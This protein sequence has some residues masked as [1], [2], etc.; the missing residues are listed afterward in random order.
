MMN[1]LGPQ[2]DDARLALAIHSAKLFGGLH[3]IEGLSL[4]GQSVFQAVQ[5]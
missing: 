3:D 5:E 1:A 2:L 4:D